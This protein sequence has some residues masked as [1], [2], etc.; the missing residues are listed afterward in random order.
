MFTYVYIL[1]SKKDERLYI[2]CT[3]DLKKRLQEHNRGDSFSTKGRRPFSLIYYEA[4]PNRKDAENRE[5][6]FKTGWGRQYIKKALRNYYS[7]IKT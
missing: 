2:G 7:E 6:F 4:Y 1:K 5:K 3:G